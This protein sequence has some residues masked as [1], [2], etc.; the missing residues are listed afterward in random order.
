MSI[1][2]KKQ[3]T[4]KVLTNLVSSALKKGTGIDYSEFK[5]VFPE[6]A[7]ETYKEI[8]T[9][10]INAFD[11]TIVRYNPSHHITPASISSYDLDYRLRGAEVIDARPTYIYSP[12]HVWVESKLKFDLNSPKPSIKGKLRFTYQIDYSVKMQSRNHLH[13]DYTKNYD[14]QFIFDKEMYLNLRNSED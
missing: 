9:Q 4:Q 13:N 12:S 3:A 1:R 5:S 6:F 7:N 11:K 10:V 14:T 8:L 2:N